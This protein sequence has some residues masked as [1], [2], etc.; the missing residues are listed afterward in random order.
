MCVCASTVGTHR[1]RLVA[2]DA[3][4]RSEVRSLSEPPRDVVIIAGIDELPLQGHVMQANIDIPQTLRHSGCATD[5]SLLLRIESA[6]RQRSRPGTTPWT[7]TAQPAWR[8][9]IP[10]RLH[11]LPLSMSQ[12]GVG[13]GNGCTWSHSRRSRSSSS[14]RSSEAS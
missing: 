13:C 10:R 12:C 7:F 1:S 2:L 11:A 14:R 9:Q 8:I 3:L 5:I 6:P 4:H